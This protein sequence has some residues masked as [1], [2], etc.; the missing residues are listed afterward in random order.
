M[1]KC[2]CSAQTGLRML[3]FQKALRLSVLARTSNGVGAIA[4]LAANDAE[5]VADMTWGIAFVS[6][7]PVQVGAVAI[8]DLTH[9]IIA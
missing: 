6:I 4:N 8:L 3:L 2:P 1:L 5:R 7:C 9:L